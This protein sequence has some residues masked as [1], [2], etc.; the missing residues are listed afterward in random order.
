MARTE[1]R[2]RTSIWS[3]EEFCALPSWA[4]RVYFLLLS[5]PGLSYCGVL[6]YRPRRW[7]KFAPDT[8]D[9]SIKKAL[10]RLAESRHVVL[11][12]DTE[13][14][15]VRT[16]IKNDGV[17]D[18]PNM[19]VAMAHDFLVID[20]PTLRAAVLE[21]LPEDFPSWLAERFP[22]GLRKGLPE[23]FLTAHARWVSAP[24]ERAGADAPSPVP[25]P[26]SPVPIAP[27]EPTQRRRD[28]LWEAV[29]DACGIQP[30]DITESSRGAYNR[31]VSDLRK[32]GVDPDEV[33]HR[34]AA[35]RM[36]WEHASLTPT[37][38]VRRWAE[39]S[40]GAALQPAVSKG[41]SALMRAQA[42][43]NQ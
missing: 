27:A 7:A 31:A 36:R 35:Y 23:G 25:S 38:L 2:V 1:A 12:L 26:Q 33:R 11:D 9:S 32:L 43:G 10:G 24:R 28:L 19:V 42:R 41:Q 5:Q 21:Q 37:A 20:S 3:D 4:Q 6:P 22:K 29:M 34:A 14:A 40:N 8:T 15:M 39:C 16:L 17:L 18:Q 30:E 13:E